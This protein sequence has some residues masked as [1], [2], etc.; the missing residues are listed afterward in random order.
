MAT[1]G[2][3]GT[4]PYLILGHAGNPNQPT[5]RPVAGALRWADNDSEPAAL[6]RVRMIK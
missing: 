3:Q 2:E 6:D 5:E 1:T 4:T